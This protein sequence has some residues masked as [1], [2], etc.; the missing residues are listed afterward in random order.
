[1]TQIRLLFSAAQALALLRLGLLLTFLFLG[2]GARAGTLSL[3]LSDPLSLALLVCSGFRLGLCLR[4]GRLFR[5]FALD[6]GV[7]GSVPRV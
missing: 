7:F 3:A 5:L 1:V 4:L 2:L 6:L